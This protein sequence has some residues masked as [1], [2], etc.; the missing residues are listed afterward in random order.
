MKKRIPILVLALV[1]AAIWG[2]VIWQETLRV[3]RS[4]LL[5]QPGDQT[6]P[7][8]IIPPGGP[9]RLPLPVPDGAITETTPTL[10][11]VATIVNADTGL[12]VLGHVTAEAGPVSLGFVPQ[13]RLVLP[14]NSPMVTLTVTATGYYTYS[15]AINPHLHRSY[16][17]NLPIKLKPLPRNW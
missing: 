12:P 17:F 15:I 13:F 5:A 1:A 10:E 9:V 6:P 8:L 16:Q 7:L 3:Q 11:V 14:A 4:P 2:A